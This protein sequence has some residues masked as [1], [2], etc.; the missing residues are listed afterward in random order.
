MFRC[1]FDLHKISCR[2]QEFCN[3]L[4]VY[5]LF[6]ANEQDQV[7]LRVDNVTLGTDYLLATYTMQL[8]Q[9]AEPLLPVLKTKGRASSSG[10]SLLISF[11][12]M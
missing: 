7:M 3:C 9:E 6:Q 11:S 10:A 2:Y 4:N 1:V 12:H 5:V 8:F